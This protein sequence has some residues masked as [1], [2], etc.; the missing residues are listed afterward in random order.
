MDRRVPW[1]LPR[2]GYVYHVTFG[3]APGTV[4]S[5]AEPFDVHLLRMGRLPELAKGVDVT[6]P[7]VHRREEDD[8]MVT[9]GVMAN[10]AKIAGAAALAACSGP[11]QPPIGRRE[12]HPDIARFEAGEGEL[13]TNPGG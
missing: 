10:Q 1:C 6:M 7:V 11:F 5:D 8:L 12:S 9:D 13:C 4:S 2:R 3:D